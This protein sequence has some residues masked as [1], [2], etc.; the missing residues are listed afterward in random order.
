MITKD[1]IPA[2]NE[3]FKDASPEEVLAYVLKEFK[4]R[5]ALSSSLSIEDQALTKMIVD[6]DKSTRIFTLD[7]GRLFP[8]TYQLIDRT[9]LTYDIKIEVFF[10]D[11]REVQRMVREEGINLF[12]N[13]IESRHRCCA[14]RK[15]EPL[16]RAFKGLDAWICGLRHEQSVTRKDMQLIEWDDQHNMVKVNPLINWTEQQVRE[17]IHDHHVPYNKLF[18]KGYPSIGCEPCTRAVKPGDDPR[19]GRWWWEAPDK[20]ECGLHQRY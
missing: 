17:Y 7:T 2:L 8:E 10:P 3:R 19:S 9:N 5:I 20:R 13:S 18:D 16:K 14:I 1:D 15:L 4:D 12:Y 6:I 11:Y